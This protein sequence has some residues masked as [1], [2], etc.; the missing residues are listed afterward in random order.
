MNK[1]DWNIIIDIRR[2]LYTN[3]QISKKHKISIDYLQ[4][5][6]EN[7]KSIRRTRSGKKRSKN[8]FENRQKSYYILRTEGKITLN[9][10]LYSKIKA[11]L[12]RDI[13]EK[14][15]N[16]FLDKFGLAPKC[17]LT[18]RNINLNNPKS[19]HLDH[20]IPKSKGGSNTFDNMG[21]LYWR[22]NIMKN[23]MSIFELK[24]YCLEILSYDQK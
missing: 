19:Y 24:Q 20:I 21:I 11:F 16:N 23:D 10:P 17:Y 6:Y 4:N 7:F 5:L 2:K 1:K 13:T 12:Q 15:L 8:I 14:D 9:H 18:G 3:Q 22:I